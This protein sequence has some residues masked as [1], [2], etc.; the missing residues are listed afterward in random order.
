VIRS[1][2]ISAAVYVSDTTGNDAAA[3]VSVTVDNTPPAVAITAPAN[4][5][6]VRG[7]VEIT[8]DVYDAYLAETAIAVNGTV[9]SDTSEYTWDTTSY[10]DGWYDITATA[11]DMVGNIGVDEIWVEVDNTPPALA[12]NELTDNPTLDD[13][14]Y[15]INGTVET[16]AILNI[17]GITI[18]H[19]GTFEYIINLTEGTNTITVTATDA[20]GNSAL[21]T[22]IRMVDTDHL[23]DYYEINVTGTDPLDG[24]SDSAHTSRNEAGNGI[25]DHIEDFDNDGLATYAEYKLGSDPFNEDTDGD[26]LH[27]AFELLATGTSLLATDTDGN[28]TTDS[29]KDA[30]GDGLTNL[31]EQTLRTNPR[32]PDTDGDT[33]SDSD[34]N[35]IY[36][37]DPL[38]RDT[39]GDGLTDDIEISLMGAD[40]MNSDTDGDGITDGN[41][42]FEQEFTN[43]NIGAAIQIT[44][45]GNLQRTL[46]IEQ[47]KSPYVPVTRLSGI[48]GD[49]IEFN[50]LE[51]F[52]TATVRI[53][54]NESNLNGSDESKL[55]LYYFDKAT[56]LPVEAS[57]QRLDTTSNY[58][59]A[60]TDHLSTWFIA[61]DTY[62][63]VLSSVQWFH[64][65]DIYSAGDQINIKVTVHNTGDTAI[66]DSVLVYF[67]E[68]DPSAGGSYLGSDTITGGIPRNGAKTATLYGYTILSS[69]INIYVRVDPLNSIV[70]KTESNNNAYKTLS[71]GP[72]NF[73]SDGDG[74]TDAEEANGMVIMS[75]YRVV[76]TDPYNP[77]S[78]G[79]GLNDGEEMGTI[80]YDSPGNPYY[81]IVSYPDTPDSDEDGLD[82]YEEVKQNQTIY[83]V[84][85]SSNARDFLMAVY[86]GRDPSPYFTVMEVS[87]APLLADTDGDEIDDGEEHI[88]GTNPCNSDSD[89][90]GIRDDEEKMYGEDPT[91]FDITPP[92]IQIDYLLVTKDSFSFKTQYTFWYTVADYG[93][94]K[95]IVLSKN[96]IER[97]RHSYLTRITTVS[98]RTYFETN[99]ETILD[100]LRTA[101]VDMYASDWNGNEENALVYHRPS[102]YG[103][104]AAELGSDT[105]Y[106]TEIAND[107][108]LL[109]G[110]VASVA[111]VPELVILIA[112]DPAGFL[113]GI[114]DLAGAIISEPTLLADLVSSLPETVKDKQ[115][116][117]N[118]YAEGTALYDSFAEGWY[119][120]YIASQVALIVVSDGAVKAVKSSEEF[121]QVTKVVLTKMDDVKATLRA[122]KGLGITEK[123]SVF[124]VD[125]VASVGLDPSG[126]AKLTAVKQVVALERVKRL[127]ANIDDGVYDGKWSPGRFGNPVE[128]LDDHFTRHGKDFGLSGNPSDIT[129]KQQYVDIAEELINKQTGVEKYY[130]TYH[131]TVGVY[132]R[133]TEKFVAGNKDGQIATLFIRE[134]DEIDNNPRFIRLI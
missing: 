16:G 127:L 116:I 106:G 60:T 88:W 66:S 109:S 32:N 15:R 13:P 48:I 131:R 63:N 87:S 47:D 104:M 34:E 7:V 119:G 19:H 64:P 3:S 22:K 12:V 129:G 79:D 26:G 73:D 76:S 72:H 57:D 45:S 70:E 23:P 54:Y 35:S 89:G 9:V 65:D 121:A 93:G 133:S 78:D 125:D 126:F 58:I 132:E 10:P 111:E 96:D 4:G 83:V 30:D 46:E 61:D 85:S 82:D 101:R 36:S 112:D 115:Q 17:N 124:L 6:A 51:S 134:A 52:E 102:M 42:S 40:P 39:D 28:N 90:D 43:D 123:V 37:T 44:G 86:E 77:D 20:A 84:D 99:L 81:N 95:D 117:E 5:S 49:F 31:R 100:A 114:R 67:Y 2:I 74:L 14:E 38:S 94:V 27:D 1:G 75:P 128:N 68:G 71:I 105:I 29:A 110:L 11:E 56:N 130:D 80:R 98:E 59:E 62:W 91:I 118:P 50:A 8:A 107:L 113:A 55:K 41:D 122:S 69:S 21:W 33:L 97:D 120:G 53:H 92:T 24:D 108:G 18:P 25:Q 103:Q